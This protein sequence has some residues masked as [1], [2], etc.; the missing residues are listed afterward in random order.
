M[1]S[2]TGLN[3]LGS[4]L[5]IL[6]IHFGRLILYAD[7]TVVHAKS[8][9]EIMLVLRVELNTGFEWLR[10]NKLKPN[11]DKTKYMVIGTKH[12]LTHILGDKI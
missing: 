10:A 3:I 2:T 9:V 12:V 8:Q 11:V 6:S 4:M 1:S 5:F 7:D